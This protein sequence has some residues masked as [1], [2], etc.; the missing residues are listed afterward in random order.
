MWVV[1][2]NKL[3]WFVSE[4]PEKDIS[5]AVVHCRW[6]STISCSGLCL[7]Y[8]KFSKNKYYTTCTCDVKFLNREEIM[9]K[10][11]GPVHFLVFDHGKSAI[12]CAH[13]NKVSVGR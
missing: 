13:S 11:H 8:L 4:L 1:F 7:N 12:H 6:Y 3:P 9:M 10:V 2:Y 5:N